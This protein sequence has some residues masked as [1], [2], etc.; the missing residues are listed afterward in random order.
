MIAADIMSE[1]KPRPIFSRPNGRPIQY[2]ETA[3][4]PIGQIGDSAN[5]LVTGVTASKRCKWDDR[6]EAMA[7]S[8]TKP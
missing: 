8:S 2:I 1:D 6:P 4:L 5:V 7:G 3:G